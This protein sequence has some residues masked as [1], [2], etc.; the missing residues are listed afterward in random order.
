MKRN[1]A[2]KAIV[3]VL[4]L[5]MALGVFASCKKDGSTTTSE[6]AGA[7]LN[8]ITMIGVEEASAVTQLTAGAVDIYAGSLPGEYLQEIKDADLNYCTSTGTNYEIMTNNAVTNEGFN[9]FSV[10]E[11]REAMNRFLDRDYICSE[12]FGGAAIP[13]IFPI[14]SVAPDYAR[15]VEYAR[16]VEANYTYDK[17][18]ATAV[19][20]E[21][22][23]GAGVEKV[24]GKY[25]YEGEPITLIFLIRTEDGLRQQI[26]DYVANELESIGFTVDRQYKVSSECSAIWAGTDPVEGQWHLYTGAW[27]AS[28][29]NR[30]SAIYFHDFTSPDSRYG[31]YPWQAFVVDEADNEILTKLANSEF[32][33]M[34]ERAELFKKAFELDP[35]YAQRLWLCDGLAYTPWND[36]ITT[37]YNLSAGIDGS[38]MTAYTIKDSTDGDVVWANSSPPFVNPVNP[39]AGTNWTYDSQYINFTQDYL[40]IDDPFTG[41]SYPKRIDGAD[42]I[43][44]SGLPVSQTYDWVNLSFEDEIAVPEDAMISFDIDSELWDL[45]D[46]DYLAGKVTEAEEALAA[47]QETA[48]AGPQSEEQTQESLDAAVTAAEEDLAAAQEVADRG[49]MTAKSKVVYHFGEDLSNF[50]WHDG[51]EIT[52]ADIMMK[53]IMDFEVGT[54][55]SA[56]YDESVAASFQSSLPYFKGWKIV[57]EDPIVIEYYSDNF[58]LDA[59]SNVTDLGTCSW[60]YD[61]T[62]AQAS[63]HAVAAANEVVKNG[64]AAYSEP[65]A[66]EN[67]SVEWL[68]MLD[69]PSVDYLK[70]AF[71]ELADSSYIPFEPTMKDYVK[72]KDAKAAYENALGFY[73][74]NGHFFI[75]CG[76]YYVS[77]VMSTEGSI[78]LTAYPDYKEDKHRWDFLSEPKIASI[79]VDGPSSVSSDEEAVFEVYVDDP[80]G[81]VYPADEIT[82]VKYLLYDSSGSIAEVSEV[83]ST[84]DG[85]YTIT[86]S[87]DTITSLGEGSSKLEVVVS[88]KSVAAP[89]IV[90]T[91]FV[92]D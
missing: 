82:S 13:R 40:V 41:L 12:I 53:M 37:S 84:E 18:A 28:G 38:T 19:I 5:I 90:P 49:Y 62:G 79:E 61:S 32:S 33:T 6:N 51:T 69:G 87:T 64:L 78:T 58:L 24:D 81:D 66:S 76:P 27:G 74:E 77:S 60:T 92:V 9:P 34:E 83:E 59:E 44:K 3:F 16:A 36:N 71:T 8:S 21:A 70:D 22:M 23:T 85:L 73:E 47:A 65:A 11:F 91:E 43:I 68:N 52:L 1:K 54:E 42:V 75:G 14:G 86:L 55:G 2:F 29:L 50:T 4:V 30:D 80:N 10:R 88:P 89:S 31:Y 67:D 72:A 7:N 63:W 56:L 48:D 46:A 17:E 57:S 45:A 25:T 15:Y 20:D 39:V 26:G 35:Y